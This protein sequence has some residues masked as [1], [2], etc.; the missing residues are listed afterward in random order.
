MLNLF[1]V[2]RKAVT[3]RETRTELEALSAATLRDLDIHPGDIRR[4]ARV[5]VYGEPR[6]RNA[7]ARRTQMPRFLV[8][9]ARA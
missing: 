4:I 7:F 1:E 3:C 2:V 6:V 8:N 9:P 5:A